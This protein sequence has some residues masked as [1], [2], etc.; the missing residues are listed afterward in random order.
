MMRYDIS[1]SKKDENIANH[2]SR[3]EILNSYDNTIA[4]NKQLDNIKINIIAN[5][6]EFPYFFNNDNTEWVNN[7]NNSKKEESNSQK[8]SNQD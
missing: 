4:K 7:P 6:H 5:A 8:N 1:D 3:D 2:Y